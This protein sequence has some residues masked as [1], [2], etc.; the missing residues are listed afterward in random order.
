[1]TRCKTY[2]FATCEKCPPVP[3][4][5]RTKEGDCVRKR[6]RQVEITEQVG[7]ERRQRREPPRNLPKHVADSSRPIFGRRSTAA[8]RDR[9]IRASSIALCCLGLWSFICPRTPIRAAGQIPQRVE[10][11][12]QSTDGRQFLRWCFPGP[13]LGQGVDPRL[14]AS[15]RR[16]FSGQPPQSRA[17]H[18]DRSISVAG[19]RSCSTGRRV[20]RPRRSRLRRSTAGQSGSHP[21]SPGPRAARLRCC[22]C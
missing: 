11:I 2:K 1:M 17:A 19:R 10:H 14:C 21:G 13:P 15:I 22:P 9:R 5:P 6:P 12:A 20:D 4:L 3:T 16:I 18:D 8:D 7:E